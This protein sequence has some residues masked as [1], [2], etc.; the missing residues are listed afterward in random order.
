MRKEGISPVT[1][2]PQSWTMHMRR[3]LFISSSGNSF[4]SRKAIAQ[5]L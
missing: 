2:S 3:T 1:A 4:R 5:S